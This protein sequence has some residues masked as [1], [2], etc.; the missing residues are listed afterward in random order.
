[1]N[2]FSTKSIFFVRKDNDVVIRAK[3]WV[4]KGRRNKYMDVKKLEKID[5]IWTPTEIHMTTKKGNATLHKTIL[6][7]SNVR[8]NQELADDEFTVRRLEKGL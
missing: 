8:Y 7:S 2:T 4:K 3:S 6:R 5:G 1:M